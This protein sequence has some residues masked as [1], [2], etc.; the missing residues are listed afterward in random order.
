M[1]HVTLTDDALITQSQGLAQE[2]PTYGFWKMFHRLRDQGETSNHKRVYRVYRQLNLNLKRPHKR[3]LPERPK[4]TLNQPEA[5]NQV[6]SMDFMSDALY[7]G[8]RFRT[9]NV[10]DDFNREACWVHVGM[11]IDSTVVVEVLQDLIELRG[12]PQQI[13]VDNGPEFISEHFAQFCKR[14][15]IHIRYI[16]PGKPTQNAY[17]FKSI[18]EVRQL[19][20]QWIQDYNF[21]RP[22][23]S[24]NNLTPVQFANKKHPN[25]TLNYPLCFGPN[26]GEAYT[27]I[28]DTMRRDTIVTMLITMDKKNV[29]GISGRHRRITQDFTTNSQGKLYSLSIG[30]SS[31]STRWHRSRLDPTSQPSHKA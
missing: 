19:S 15:G 26:F 12:A 4:H 7:H 31:S 1:L 20:Y 29:W 25:L 2:H 30:S 6:W 13:R 16:L 24:L 23:Q 27:Q 28:S 10:I 21:R 14:H 3:R 9:F 11:S 8:R 18:D 17:I 5:P 22:H